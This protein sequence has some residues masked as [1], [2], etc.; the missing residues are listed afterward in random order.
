MERDSL[1][2][3]QEITRL[4]ALSRNQVDGLRLLVEAIEKVLAIQ[5]RDVANV[6]ADLR[7]RLTALEQR[8]AALE[9]KGGQP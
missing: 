2:Q 3:W 9:Q 6:V 5:L 4:L 8:L 7:A 1:E